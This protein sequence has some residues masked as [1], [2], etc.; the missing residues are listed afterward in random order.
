MATSETAHEERAVENPTKM[1]HLLDRV[2]DGEAV[3]VCGYRKRDYR[4]LFLDRPD[5]V[6]CEAMSNHA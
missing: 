1:R 6:A 4:V 2:E 3:A 5:C